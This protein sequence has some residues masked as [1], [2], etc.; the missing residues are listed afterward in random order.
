MGTWGH[1]AFDN[2]AAMD[3]DISSPVL[4]NKCLKAL[5]RIKTGE[6]SKSSWDDDGADEPEKW[7]QALY[8]LGKRLRS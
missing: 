5:H 7:Y 1:N 6:G 2:D 3:F 4:I 8:D